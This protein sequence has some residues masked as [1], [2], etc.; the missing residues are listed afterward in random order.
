MRLARAVRVGETDLKLQVTTERTPDGA[1]TIEQTLK[2]LEPRERRQQCW[3][4]VPASGGRR[5]A[6]RC[7]R[8]RTFR[9]QSEA[10]PGNLASWSC[11]CGSEELGGPAI[12][13]RRFRISDV[14]GPASSA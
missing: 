1:L 7:P 10:P 8:E 13:S 12:I 5:P 6:S 14:G 11:G 9:Y 3:L 2:N 4:Y